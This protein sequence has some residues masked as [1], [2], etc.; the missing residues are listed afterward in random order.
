MTDRGLPHT[1][2][3]A[4]TA[5]ND[6]G[7]GSGEE[8]FLLDLDPASLES[9]VHHAVTHKL[10]SD[11]QLRDITAV[12]RV[13]SFTPTPATATA[14]SPAPPA[15]EQRVD[16]AAQKLRQKLPPRSGVAYVDPRAA[17]MGVR[18]YLPTFMDGAL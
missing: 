11:I 4:L 2:T 12:S 13:V 15:V 16:D 8:A 14:H 17:G 9:A 6:Q 7:D 3:Y 10:R 1:G 18:A 5:H